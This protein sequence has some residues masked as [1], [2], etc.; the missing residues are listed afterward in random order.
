MRALIQR[1]KTNLAKRRKAAA[2]VNREINYWRSRLHAAASWSERNNATLMLRKRRGELRTVLRSVRSAERV[3]R[4]NTHRPG[5]PVAM[6]DSV[7][8]SEIPP[9]ALAVAGYTSGNWPTFPEL[10][11]RFPRAHRLS[12]AINAAHDADCLD[13]EPGDATPD[14]APRWVKRQHARGLKRPVV[15]ASVSAMQD[16]IGRLTAAGLSRSSY[17][18]WTAHYTGQPHICSA[19]CGNGFTGTADATQWTDHSGGRNL[20]QSLC[21]AGFFA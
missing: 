18:V 8:V 15:Y 11:A 10:A 5:T 6:Y 21:A 20:D 13:C 14:Q 9:N 4:R 7:T 16:V 12:I 3:I 19:R 1:W 17:R 2:F